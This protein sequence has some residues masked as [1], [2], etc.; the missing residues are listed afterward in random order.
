M[1]HDEF[2]DAIVDDFLQHDVNPI[3]GMG[4][5][6]QTA[7]VHPGA[8]PDMARHLRVF[9]LLSSYCFAI[10][11]YKPKLDKIGKFTPKSEYRKTEYRIYVKYNIGIS[12]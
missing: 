1:L 12:I 6:A 9:T 11:L 3:I 10:D 7:N 4:S 5:I 8:Q 2:I